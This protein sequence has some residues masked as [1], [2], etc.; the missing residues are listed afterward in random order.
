MDRCKCAVGGANKGEDAS[1]QVEDVC[2]S[3]HGQIYISVNKLTF[4]DIKQVYDVC[5][6]PQNCTSQDSR[7]T[8][9]V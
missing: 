9:F 1:L 6:V 8:N 2:S 3:V 7:V 4:K 5:K